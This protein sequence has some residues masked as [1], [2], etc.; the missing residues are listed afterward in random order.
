M[1][2]SIF[3]EGYKIA[4]F[5][6]EIHGKITL[7]CLIDSFIQVSEDESVELSVGVSDV[8]ATGVTWIVVQQDLHIHRLPRANE[9][10]RIET[11]AASHTNYF[12]RRLYRVYD[13]ADNLLVDVESLWVMM[14]LQTRKM[15]KINPALTE[16]FGSEHVKRLPRLT[17]IPN[18]S[19][20]PDQTMTYPVL[21][22]DIDFNG[23]VSNTH[24]VGWITNTLDFDFLRD[25]LPTDFSIK[26][27]DEV[28]YGDEVVSQAQFL[29]RDEEHPVTVHQIMAADQLRATARIKWE[30]IKP[31]KADA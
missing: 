15:V 27:A 4:N 19:G 3:S 6:T 22:T 18:L 14:D 16:P 8:Q 20:E 26:Y 5:Q 23:H 13:E 10:V 31:K 12:A 30:K 29:D 21:F 28:R 17:K 24:Y 25:Y 2:A 1:P 9:R 11:Q 7:Q